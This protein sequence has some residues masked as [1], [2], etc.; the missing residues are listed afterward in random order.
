MYVCINIYILIYYI[1]VCTYI[2]YIT[3]FAYQKSLLVSS[4]FIPEETLSQ[5][6]FQFICIV[7]SI[8]INGIS[9][10]NCLMAFVDV[11]GRSVS[12]WD[13][14]TSLHSPYWM[15]RGSLVKEVRNRILNVRI[16]SQ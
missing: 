10:N 4:Q 2:F 12:R 9:F 13:Q 14:G 16:F 11:L 7:F 1:Y 6:F 3:L 8:V 15:L 5:I